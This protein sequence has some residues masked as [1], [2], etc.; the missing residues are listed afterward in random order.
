[1]S[2]THEK[3]SFNGAVSWLGKASG[4]RNLW[5]AQKAPNIH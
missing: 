4:K 1:M 5:G 3:Y 2:M